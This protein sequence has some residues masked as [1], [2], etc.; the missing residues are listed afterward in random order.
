M[1]ITVEQHSTIIKIDNSSK[2]MIDKFDD[3]A[4]LSLF[5]TG[6]NSSVVLTREETEAVIQALRLALEAA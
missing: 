1:R 6:G 3:G 2:L 4:H 5:F